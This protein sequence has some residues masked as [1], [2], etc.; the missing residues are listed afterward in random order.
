MHVVAT[1]GHVDHGKSTLVL[2]LT[3]MDPDRF[4]EEKARGLTIDLGFAWTRLASGRELAFVDVPGHVRFIKNMLAGV[5]AVDASLFVVAA[6]EGWKPQSEE[7]LR[8]LEVLG[9]EHGLV[10]LTKVGLVD[11]E[12]LELAHLDLADHLKGTFLEDA[13]VVDVDAVSGTGLADLQ[14]ALDRMLE[15]TP[16]APDRGR[17]RLWVDRSFAAKGS[18]TVVTGTLAGGP[19]AVDDDLVVVGGGS[20]SSAASA[21]R[22]RVRSLQSHKAKLTHASPGR[23]LAVNLAGIHHHEVERGHALVRPDQWAPTRRLDCSLTVLASLDHDVSRR[24]A[25]QAYIGSGE[26]PVRMRVLGAEALAPGAVGLVRL[27]LP[28]ALP[29]LPGDRYVL[30]ESGRAETVGGGEVLDVAPV[31]PAYRARPTRSVDRVI[32]ER[33]WVEA[34]VLERLTGERRPATVGGRWVVDPGVRTAAE[35]RLA[36]AVDE[37]GPLGLDVAGLD[38]RERALLAG[39]DGVT[40]DAG[41]AKRGAGG[42]GAAGDPLAGHPYLAALQASPFSPPPPE[43]VDRAELRELAR[44]GLVVEREGVWFSPSAL[45]EAARIVARLLVTSPEGVTVA[46]VRDALGTSRK[47][48]LPVLAHLDA[49]GVTRRRGDLRI[50]GPR[51]PAPS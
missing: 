49:S 33:G 16:T 22:A 15:G 46:Q 12:W 17:P 11:D 28:V 29:L 20:P 24:G 35:E 41:R 51:L 6:T 45:E 19:L 38:E 18:G 21:P 37:A 7:H 9:V 13:D 3:G 14:A 27:H 44:R 8:I 23:R 31:L 25:Y 48:I 30:R 2:A 34:E 26:H 1:A 39:L 42:E 5:G 50:G 10:A 40:V 36:A 4:A 32:S 43:G 47:Y